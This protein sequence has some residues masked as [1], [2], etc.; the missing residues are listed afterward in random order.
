MACTIYTKIF[1]TKPTL[2]YFQPL[3]L[4]SPTLPP[5]PLP[6]NNVVLLQNVSDLLSIASRNISVH[7]KPTLKRGGG[8]G[9]DIKKL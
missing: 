7:G 1:V 3:G 6:L 2:T 9:G 4:H 5:P 8:E